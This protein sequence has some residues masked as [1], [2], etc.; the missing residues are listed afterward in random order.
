M[1]SDHGD[2]FLSG[3]EEIDIE[4]LSG[5]KKAQ[6]VAEDLNIEGDV[7]LTRTRSIEPYEDYHVISVSLDALEP[8][9]PIPVSKPRRRR[10][11]HC[12]VLWTDVRL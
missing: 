12:F 10:G 6:K 4:G 9:R 2:R 7:E 8:Y 5:F 11:A 3:L 1:L